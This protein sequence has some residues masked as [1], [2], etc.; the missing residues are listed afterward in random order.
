MGK[1]RKAPTKKRIQT[2]A[3]KDFFKDTDI[4]KSVKGAKEIKVLPIHKIAEIVF[5]NDPKKNN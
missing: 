2:K 4:V 5:G 1:N 3:D